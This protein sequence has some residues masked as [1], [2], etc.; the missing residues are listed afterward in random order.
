MACYD[1]ICD[2]CGAT[3]VENIPFEARKHPIACQCGGWMQWQFPVTAILGFQPFEPF[4]HEGWGVDINGRGE[5]R[6]N[7]RARGLQESGDKVHGGRDFE[8]SRHAN[9][10]VP[11]SPQGI[12][13]SDQQRETDLNQKA[14]GEMEVGTVG[15]D[16]VK[17]KDL[18]DFPE[19]DKKKYDAA[20]EKASRQLSDIQ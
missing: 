7:M 19:P 1:Y 5:L 18:K 13:L 16:R 3:S 6:E 17:V 14:A 8:T 10:M 15:G 4:H 12:S 9:T 11:L 20:I 2:D